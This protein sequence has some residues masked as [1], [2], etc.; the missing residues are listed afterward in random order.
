MG[1]YFQLITISLLLTGIEF[2]FLYQGYIG[3]GILAAAA[4]LATTVTA[5][6]EWHNQAIKQGSRK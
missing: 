3:I 2:L 1:K 5:A 4:G 6:I